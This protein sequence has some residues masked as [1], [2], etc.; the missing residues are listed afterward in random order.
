MAY[1]YTVRYTSQFKK[2]YKKAKK[3][4][5]EVDK[6]QEI[7]SYIAN[8]IPLPEQYKDH[9]LEGNWINHREC[10]IQNDWLFKLRYLVNT[11]FLQ[12]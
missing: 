4:H 12:V 8:G 5:Y 11:K 10:H 7:L 1:K 2:D 9:A 3:R 6:L